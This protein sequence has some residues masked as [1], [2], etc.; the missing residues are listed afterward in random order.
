MMPNPIERPIE[1]IILPKPLLMVETVSAR[2]IPEAIPMYMAA[3]MSDIAG[4]KRSFTIKNR[5]SKW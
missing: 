3:K 5:I 1:V 4:L 2:P